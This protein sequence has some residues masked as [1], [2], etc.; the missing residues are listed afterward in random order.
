M[1]RFRLVPALALFSLAAAPLAAADG[2]PDNSFW[3]D[4]KVYFAGSGSYQVSAVLAAPDGRA[5]V[6]GTHAPGNGA[7]EW[8]WRAVGSG[9][10]ASTCLFFPPGG[11]DAGDARAAGFDALG[12][13]VVAG[14]ARYAGDERIAVARFSFP[15]CA[16][17]TTFDG[18]G[19]YTLDIPGGEDY[20]LGLD[21]SPVGALTFGGYHRDATDNDMVVLQL[22]DSGAPLTGFSADGWLTLDVSGAELDDAAY[23]VD[24]DAQGRVLAGGTTSYGANSSNGDFIVARFTSAG[25]LDSTFDGDG[26][27]RIAF[28]LGG[29]NARYDILL[30]LTWDPETGKILVAGT[31]QAANTWDLALA[32]LTSAGALDPSFSSDGKINNNLGFATARLQKVRVDS[33]G[34]VL[35]AGYATPFSGDSQSDFLAVRYTP[36]GLLD[37]TFSGDGWTTVPFNVGPAGSHDD[38]GRGLALDAGR[39]LLAGE[40]TFDADSN[41]RYGLAR[42]QSSL[43]FA[44]GF[45]GSWLLRWA[46]AAG[47]P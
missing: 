29:S 34:R 24:V 7:D 30:D 22:T 21:I 35:A 9:S 26:I 17:D 38:F 45:E 14:S 42:L 43:V 4:G 1:R 16:L 46:G 40:V 27:A 6:V 19:Y 18:D 3:T 13:L 37:T 2:D 15:T 31:A 44:D 33:L 32:R 39:V 41:L 11:A 47:V 5:V 36:A 23:A 28:D 12:R 8:Y 10:S 25:A 20:L